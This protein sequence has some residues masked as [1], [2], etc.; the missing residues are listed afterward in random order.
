MTF[1]S[2]V[3]RVLLVCP[4]SVTSGKRSRKRNARVGGVRNSM[5]LLDLAK[6]VVLDTRADAKLFMQLCKRLKL[7]TLDEGNHIHVQEIV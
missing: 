2:K 6:D 7:W 1:E 4:G 5:H 3:R